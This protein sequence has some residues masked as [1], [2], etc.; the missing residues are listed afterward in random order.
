MV[1]YY[2]KKLP[3]VDDVV[4][5]KVID[6]SEYGIKVTLN[7]F[8][9]VEGFINCGE[10]SRKKRVNFNKIFTVGKE[11]LVIVTGINAEKKFIDLSKRTIGD[12]DIKLF[13]SKHKTH[14]QLY[15]LF[16]HF[17]IKYKNLANSDEINNDSMY[18]F[19]NRTLWEIQTEYEDEYI[20]EKLLNKDTNN[21]ILDVIDYNSWD[22]TIEQLKN[23][24]DFHIDTKINRVKPELIDTIKL[25]TYHSTGLAD[26]KYSM[27]F[28][29][30]PQ[31]NLLNADFDI[32]INYITGSTYTINI[33]QRDFDLMG[34]NSIEDALILLKQNIKSRAIEKNIQN[35]I[36]L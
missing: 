23:I 17:Y 29:D 35:Q 9:D 14:I 26:I 11:V 6:I 1:Y 30:F 15:N 16:K 31:F 33:S 3:S 18:D 36:P 27:N 22:L 34:T 32:K 2:K 21:E 13:T 25:L 7:E 12:E 10:V 19:M 20:L 5:A 24:V 28:M 8:D 4:I